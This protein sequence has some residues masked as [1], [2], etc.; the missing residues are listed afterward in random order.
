MLVVRRTHTR[1]SSPSGILF[2]LILGADAVGIKRRMAEHELAEGGEGD[3]QEVVPPLGLHSAPAQDDDNKSLAGGLRYGT[4][5]QVDEEHRQA[6]QRSGDGRG[7]P[8][9]VP[10]RG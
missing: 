6:L 3:G 10:S 5:E 1:R 9:Q 4:A 7:L 2:G 8:A